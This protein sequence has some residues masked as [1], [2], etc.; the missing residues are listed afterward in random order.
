[1]DVFNNRLSRA[2]QTVEVAFGIL[3]ARFRVLFNK[4]YADVE[5]ALLIIGASVLLHNYIL[6]K[7]PLKGREEFEQAKKDYE[8]LE[9]L[10][11]Y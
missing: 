3:A 1:M 5:N 2:R 6:D 7:R 11:H 9:H 10:P 4:V 8:L